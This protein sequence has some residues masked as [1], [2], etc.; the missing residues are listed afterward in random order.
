[1]EQ[2]LSAGSIGFNAEVT[3]KNDLN[4][5]ELLKKVE[6]KDLTKFG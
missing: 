5:D 2:R 3:N 4:I 6:P 1:M